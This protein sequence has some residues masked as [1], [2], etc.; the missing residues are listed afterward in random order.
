MTT[1]RER[2]IHDAIVEAW[3]NKTHFA[4]LVGYI[5]IGDV[6]NGGMTDTLI[7][8]AAEAVARMEANS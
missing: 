4:P 1:D 6:R 5:P 7:W 2:E 8:V 3:S